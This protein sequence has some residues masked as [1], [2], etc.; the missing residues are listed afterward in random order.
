[1]EPCIRCGDLFDRLGDDEVLV[2]DVRSEEDWNLY[3]VHIPGAL[4]MSIEEIAQFTSALPDDEL[5]VLCS[6]DSDLTEVRRVYRLLRGRGRTAVCLEG[7]LHA[8]VRQGYPIERH[9][10]TETEPQR[11][12]V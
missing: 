8:W 1:M 3:D 12:G 2:L 5:I 4:R 11:A 9:A 6:L 7:G 10:R